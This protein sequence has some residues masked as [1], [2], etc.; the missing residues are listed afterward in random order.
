MPPFLEHPSTVDEKK[1]FQN[2][3]HK[4]SICDTMGLHWMIQEVYSS[5]LFLMYREDFQVFSVTDILTKII[6]CNFV[7][8]YQM[9][10]IEWTCFI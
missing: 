10:E 2:A 8:Y 3:E 4:L 1:I 7:F 9:K 5:H 6:V